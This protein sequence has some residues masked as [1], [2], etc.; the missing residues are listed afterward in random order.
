M[1]R[2]AHEAVFAEA[3]REHMGIFLKTAHAFATAADRD[4]LVQEMLVTVWRALPSFDAQ[5]CKLSTF[6]YRV[7]TNRALNWN[8]T[9]RRHGRQLEALQN[10]PQLAFDEVHDERQLQRLEWLYALIRELPPLDR[11]VLL[12]HLDR[13]SHREIGEVTGMSENHVGVRLHRI[14]RWLADRKGA[15]DGT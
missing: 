8:R 1:D 15:D 13:L 14:R 6:V 3:T 7:A 2:A 11:T 10:C 9:R 12:L 5:R 4:D